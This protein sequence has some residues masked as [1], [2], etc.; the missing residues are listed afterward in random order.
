[1]PMTTANEPVMPPKLNTASDWLI[2]NAILCLT[3]TTL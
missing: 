1:M 3:K 2:E